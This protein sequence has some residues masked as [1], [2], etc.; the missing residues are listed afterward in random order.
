MKCTACWPT[1]SAHLIHNPTLSVVISMLFCQPIPSR[2]TS[3]VLILSVNKPCI[4]TWCNSKYSFNCTYLLLTSTVSPPC[5]LTTWLTLSV[6]KMTTDIVGPCGVALNVANSKLVSVKNLRPRTI[7]LCER[8]I[9]NLI[10]L[11]YE[12]LQKAG[13]RQMFNIVKSI[14]WLQVSPHGQ[15]T[16]SL[17]RQ[18][19]CTTQHHSIY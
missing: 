16:Q 12:V 5:P 2:C 8:L 3:G 14:H 17:Q 10:S 13:Q 4:F 1:T 19:F 9:R 7:F 11:F 15:S 6:T 18:R